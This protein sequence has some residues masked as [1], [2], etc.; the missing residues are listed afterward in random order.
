MLQNYVDR[1]IKISETAI[2]EAKLEGELNQ[3]LKELLSSFDIPYDP[4]VNVT[5]KIQ[6]LTQVNSNR[7]DSLF[8][9]VVLDYKRPG[10]LEKAANIKKSQKKE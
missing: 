10:I 1:I 5:L 4:I 3:V 7:T 2:S 9:H 6:G 8:G